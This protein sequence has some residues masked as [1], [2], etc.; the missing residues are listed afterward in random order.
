MFDWYADPDYVTESLRVEMRSLFEDYE[1]VL[2]V[3]S[4]H[5]SKPEAI[6]QLT[7]PRMHHSMVF[8]PTRMH[9][10]PNLKMTSDTPTEAVRKSMRP[11]VQIRRI[12]R[13]CG[14]ISALENEA[15]VPT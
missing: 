8:Q 11:G 13:L 6:D 4:L 15:S 3:G 12:K 7:P 10:L 14:R 5:W 9:A 1:Q 2:D